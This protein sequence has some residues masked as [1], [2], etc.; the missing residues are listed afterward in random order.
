MSKRLTIFLLMLLGVVLLL[1]Q[2][3]K[4][5]IKLNATKV[6]L[7]GEVKLSWTKPL[8]ANNTTQYELYRAKLPDTTSV[9]VVSTLDTSFVDKVPQVVSTAPQYIGYYVLAKTGAVTVKSNIVTVPLPGVPLLGSF[10]LEGKVDSGKVKLNWQ[11]PPINTPID[12]YLVYGMP[13]PIMGALTKIDSTKGLVS[14]TD[15]PV[16]LAGTK[17]MFNYYVRAKLSTGEYLQ[18]TSL[19]LTIENKIPRDEVKFTSVPN[20]SG[21]KDVKYIYTAKAVSSDPNTAIRYIG[22]ATPGMLTVIIPEFKIDSVTGVVDWTPKEKGYYNVTIYAKSNK[23]GASKQFFTIVVSGLNGIIQG[24]VTDT[25]ATPIPNVIVE[26]FKADTNKAISFAY[27]ARTDNNGNYRI[28]RVDQG[29]YKIRANAPSGKYESQWYEGKREAAQANLVP[30]DDS[31]KVGPTVVNFKLR[32]GVSTLPKITVKGSVTDTTGLAI[33]NAETRVFFVRAE[34]AL[35]LSGGSSIVAENFR[36]YFEFNGHGDFRLE[37]LSE[38]VF[39]SKVDSVGNYKVELPIGK[40][41][42]FARAK[43]YTTEFYFESSDLLSASIFIADPTLLI[44]Q[45]APNFT[46]SP[47]PPVVLGGIKGSVSDSVKVLPI[48][49]RVVAFRDGWRF[50]DNFKISRAYVTDTDSLGVFSFSELLPGNYVVMALPLGNY[51][52]SFYSVDTNSNRWKRATKIVVN[53]NSIDNINIF[54]RPFGTSAN[55]YS[56]ITGNVNLS[57][58]NKQDN[59]PKTGAF[60]FALRNGEVA[61]Y[62][63]TDGAGNYTIDGLSPGSYSVFVDKVGYNESASKDVNVSYDLAGSPVNGNASFTINSVLSVSV[64]STVQPTTYSLEQNY[65]NPFNPSTTIKYSLPNN[66]AVSL[67]VYNLIG[68]EVATLINSF[69]TSGEYAVTFNASN[70]SSGV[71]FYRLESGSFSVVKK[72]LFVK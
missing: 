9:L 57:I 31:A 35:N 25:L 45:N 11:V 37:G 52:P 66:S 32:G 14:V 64:S 12:Y 30:V 55:G 2:T 5:Q 67:K 70:L 36:K 61:G 15:I 22:W 18:S 46:L 16:V 28:V 21:Q 48:P 19:Q 53:G 68:Q 7:S 59:S 62:A 29:V 8:L 72:M 65:P 51:A 24:K 54:V 49:S 58:G 63:I 69:Q 6:E 17:Q 43:G 26:V 40:Y 3:T 60:V 44:L 23:G 71:Y 39:K 47:I 38:F 1:A 20:P 42:A 50:N 41:I 27:S 10:R 13:M 56:G 34:F 4:S 33:N